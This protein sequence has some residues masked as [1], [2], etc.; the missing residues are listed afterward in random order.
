MNPRRIVFATIGSLGDLH[1]YIAIG[2]VLRERGHRPV[3]ATTDRYQGAVEAAGIDYARVR[4]DEAQFGGLEAIASRV[5]NSYRGPSI[6]IRELIMPYVREQYA[7]LAQTCEGADLLVTHPL[8][9][10]GPLVH[11][12]KGVRWVSSMLSP[13]SLLSKFD[14]P[15]MSNALLARLLHKLGATAYGP[16]LM[17]AGAVLRQW[18]KPLAALRA[19]LGLPR[20]PHA[21][22]MQ[23]QF[24]PR[25]NLGLFSPLLAARQPDWPANT[26]LT[27]FARYDGAAPPADTRERFEAFM[28]AGAPPLVFGLGSSMVMAAGDFWQQA[29]LAAQGLG[30]RAILLTG[31]PLSFPLPEGV[32]AFDYLPYSLAFARAAAVVHT[33]GIGSLAQA[34]AAGRPQLI[35]PAAFDQP[36]N[37]RRAVALG[38]ARSLPINRVSAKRL[39]AELAALLADPAVESAARGVAALLKDEDGATENGAN[40]SGATKNGA[41]RA[42][43]ELLRA[44]D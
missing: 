35:V 23:G 3:I 5:F 6:L 12:K 15:L 4:P 11:A 26:L 27:G 9:V 30:R 25:L 28:A 21:A 40:K 39:V 38:V 29:I 2:R 19:D 17:L 1:P 41:T 8:A 34:L 42:A 7:D 32:A 22:L 18:E 33:G 24:S 10:A 44:V 31:T 20:V 13:P 37:A 36:D 43:D 14:P 16:L